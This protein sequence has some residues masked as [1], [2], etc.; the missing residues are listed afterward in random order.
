MR[1][2]V[3]P[4]LAAL[5]LGGCIARTAVG[6]ATL[7]VRAGAKVVDWTTTSQAEADRN[8]GRRMRKDEEREGRERREWAK[9]CARTPDDPAC[10][11]YQ[12]YRAG[13]Q[14]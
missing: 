10:E 13:E 4:A 9:R 11:H 7:P 14:Q 5:L 3:L 6:V 2:W 8:A 1:R 12:G